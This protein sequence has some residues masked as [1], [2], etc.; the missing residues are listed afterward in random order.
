M[1]KSNSGKFIITLVHA[2]I[3]WALCGAIIGIGRE[4]TTMKTTIIIHLIG[5]PVIFT[6]ISMVYYKYY[7]FFWPLKTAILFLTFVMFMDFLVVALFIE[8]S[9][10]MFT[11]FMGT[12]FPFILIFLSTFLTG[13]FYKK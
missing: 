7:Y 5:A 11:S 4:I 12:W 2:F 10:E 8:K 6:I 13:L 3:G 1:K 9:F